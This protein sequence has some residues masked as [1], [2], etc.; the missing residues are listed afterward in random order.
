MTA[1]KKLI[2]PRHLQSYLNVAVDAFDG[3]IATAVL[4]GDEVLASAGGE[5][6]DRDAEGTVRKPLATADGALAELL[7]AP[8]AG[9]AIAQSGIEARACLLAE[10]LQTRIDAEEARRAV[11][12][13]TLESYRELSLLH[14]AAV[15]LNRSLQLTDVAAALLREFESGRETG[16]ADAGIVFWRDPKT[17]DLSP[18]RSFEGDAEQDLERVGGSEL[19]RAVISADK[20]EIVNELYIDERW[21][22]EVPNLTALLLIPLSAHEHCSGAL[23]LG[24]FGNGGIFSAAD[25]KRAAT[26]ASVAAAALHNA[27]LFEEVLEIKNYNESVLQNLSNGVITLDGDRRITKTNRAALSILGRANEDLA[28]QDLCEVFDGANAWVAENVSEVIAAGTSGDWLDRGLKNSAGDEVSINL[29]AVPLTGPEET[30]VGTILVLE[31]ITREKRIKGTM[32]RFMSDA[33][34]EK[35]LTA[36]ESLLGGTSQEV[37]V[38]FSDI[39]SFTRLSE[40]LSAREMVAT[41]NDYFGDMV[42]IIFERGGTLDKFIGDA[43]MAIFGAPFVTKEDTG[44]AVATAIEMLNR[45]R[46]LNRKWVAAD[47]PAL[48]IGVGINTGLVVAGTIGSSR[49]MDYTVIGDHVNLAARIES[50]NKY[51]GTKILISEH[52]LG[53]LDGAEHV[54]EIDRVRVQGREQPVGIYEVLDYHTDQSFPS[55]EKV[56]AAYKAGLAHYRNRDWHQAMTCFAAALEHHPGDRPAQ[57]MFGRCEELES[58]PPPQDWSAVTDLMEKN[59]RRR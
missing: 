30:A 4:V 34:V 21:R 45:L 13:E 38:L 20:G 5:A 49:R 26:L 36:D 25:L 9:S 57:L 2:K 8:V 19:I 12:A 41:L 58:Q 17:G 42:D 14:R 6:P 55:L 54:R 48:D 22:G 52:T 31:D 1:L 47:R 23:V 18:L 50:A 39:R 7:V 40:Q 33:V 46:E 44:N 51:Y 59:A 29:V 24:S 32:V 35:L 53:R 3:A 16:I 11:T 27:R 28:G 10:S 43:I 37:S 56:V 15:D